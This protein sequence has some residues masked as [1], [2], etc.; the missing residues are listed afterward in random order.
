MRKT[1][2][3][4]Y[5]TRCNLLTAALDVF[6]QRGVTR[7]SLDE[8][9]KAAGVTRG[10]LYWHFKNKEDLFDALFQSHFADIEQQL[11]EA[12]Q[13]DHP[14]PM[15]RLVQGIIEYCEKLTA[16][17]AMQ[18]F[19]TILHLRCEQTEA[20]QGITN[21]MNQYHQRWDTQLTAIINAGKQ[22]GRFPADLNTERALTHMKSTLHGLTYH[23]LAQPQSD[24]LKHHGSAIVLCC[25]DSL[26]HS[27]HLREQAG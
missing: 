18:K 9:A 17:P 13:P 1:K 20:N 10:A 14:D 7:A 15:G 26:K 24:L 2:E 12:S 21:L 27:P 16:N 11:H 25:I 8:I 5:Q 23:W 22:Q 6:Y 4:A 19:S 3:E